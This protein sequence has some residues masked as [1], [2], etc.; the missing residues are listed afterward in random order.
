MLEF[1]TELNNLMNILKEDHKEYLEVG[2]D[3]IHRHSWG[4]DAPKLATVTSI[5]RFEDEGT[6]NLINKISWESFKA[7]PR[8]Y[9]VGLD[10]DNKRNGPWAYNY[11]I[12]P[13][14]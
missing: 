12:N 11:Q 6:D 2:D 9:V 10:Q 8:E 13:I 14:G 4:K 3:V 1:E 7:K 5:Q